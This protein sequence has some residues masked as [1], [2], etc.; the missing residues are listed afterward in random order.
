M[1]RKTAITAETVIDALGGPYAVGRLFNIDGRVVWN[2]KGRG[3]PA[4]TYVALSG[5][6]KKQGIHAPPSLWGQ[7]E[8]VSR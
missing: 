6:L 3:L 7:R 2:W 1:P 5:L 4:D 8:I